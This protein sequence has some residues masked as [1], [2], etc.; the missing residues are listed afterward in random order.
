MRVVVLK[1][2]REL[3]EFLQKIKREIFLAFQFSRP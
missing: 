2:L 3:Q 1:L